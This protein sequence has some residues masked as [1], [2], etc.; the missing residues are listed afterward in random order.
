MSFSIDRRFRKTTL[1]RNTRWQFRR[2]PCTVLLV[3]SFID[4]AADCFENRRDAESVSFAILLLKLNY[5][6][7]AFFF[8]IHLFARD[9]LVMNKL[10]IEKTKLTFT[11]PV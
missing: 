11:I 5:C 10:D 4:G 8:L 2:G 3:K 6:K 1:D 9:V 7:K